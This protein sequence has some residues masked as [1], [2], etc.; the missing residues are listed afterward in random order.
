MPIDK[1]LV[2]NE[3]AILAAVLI[4]RVGIRVLSQ[5]DAL[6]LNAIEAQH[7][8]AGSIGAADETD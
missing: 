1:P 5:I 2:A 6:I 7:S 3:R 8:S 4:V